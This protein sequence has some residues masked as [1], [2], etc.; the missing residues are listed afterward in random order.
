MDRLSTALKFYVADKIQSDAGW[1]GVRCCCYCILLFVSLSS[2][3]YAHARVQVTVILS[4]SNVP[5]E[6]E[7][8]IMEYIRRQRV[9]PG[10]NPQTSHVLCGL[11]RGVC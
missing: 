8:K 10:Y 2:V 11:V 3:L 7:H 4:D 1:R 5:G 6:G 9:Q